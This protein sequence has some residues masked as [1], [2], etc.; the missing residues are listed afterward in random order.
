MS[1]HIPELE[2]FR[3]ACREEF[4]FLVQSYGFHEATPDPTTGGFAVRFEKDDLALEIVG[5][6][7]DGTPISCHL[8]RGGRGPLGLVYLVPANDRPRRSTERDRMGQRD[9]VRD[10]A[11]LARAHA[12]DVLMGDGAR[13]ESALSEWERTRKSTGRA[14]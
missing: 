9:H 3:Q 6:L 4:A 8:T 10:Q 12:H 13:F 2:E 5:E 1:D 11:Q 7:Y 14:G